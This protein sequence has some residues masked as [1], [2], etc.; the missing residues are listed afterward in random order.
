MGA[1][2]FAW[3]DALRRRYFPQKRNILP[4]HITLFHHLP[5]SAAPELVSRIKAM[6]RGPRPAAE[7]TGVINLGGGVALR[8]ESPELLAMRMELADAFHGLLTAQDQQRPRLHITI[9]NK[10]EP[11]VARDL[12]EELSRSFRPRF[13]QIA[14]FGLWRYMGGPWEPLASALFRN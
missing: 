14:G 3:A 2:G 12:Y 10:V 4:A 13:L 11:R 5:P 6:V 8:V 7:V 9:Q 1:E